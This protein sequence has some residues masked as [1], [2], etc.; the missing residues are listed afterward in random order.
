[1]YFF[2]CAHTGKG[3]GG[4]AEGS[5][6]EAARRA[7]AR[8]QAAGC[9]WAPSPAPPE[10]VTLVAFMTPG[11]GW[12]AR[13]RRAPPGC[14]PEWAPRS[15]SPG[16]ERGGRGWGRRRRG[17]GGARGG[18]RGRVSVRREAQ[19]PRA[20][21]AAPSARVAFV[22]GAH[23]RASERAREVQVRETEAVGKEAG[24]LSPRSGCGEWTG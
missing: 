7:L 3:V 23:R 1:M 14:V 19:A 2:L 9:V 17:L 16:G 4:R 20:A 22:P 8:A 10:L 5:R 13:R 24:P 6:G 12:G 21:P 11:A 18:G 15:R